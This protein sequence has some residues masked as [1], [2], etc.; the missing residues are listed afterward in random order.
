MSIKLECQVC[1]CAYD[2]GGNRPVVTL[3]GHSFC[4]EC[5]TLLQSRRCPFCNRLITPPLADNIQLMDVIEAMAGLPSAVTSTEN[6]YVAASYPY[7][8]ILNAYSSG[9]IIGTY[10]G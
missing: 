1:F 4:R 10:F 2:L 9:T 3:C 7:P 6:E 5:A 8:D